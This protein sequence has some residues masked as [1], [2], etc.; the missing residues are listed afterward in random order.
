NGASQEAT[1]AGGSTNFA[2]DDASI[3]GG[4]GNIAGLYSSIGGGTGNYASGDYATIAGGEENQSYAFYTTIGGGFDNILQGLG[5]AIPGGGGLNL[6]PYSFGFN[7]DINYYSTFTHTDLTND[8]GVGYFGNVNVLIGN[9]DST[10]RQLRFY[11][12]NTD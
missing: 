8:T 5:S 2:Y 10:A 7:G 4:A 6:G 3:G 11:G 9:V 1:V 12:P